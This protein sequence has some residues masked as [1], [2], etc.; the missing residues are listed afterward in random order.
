MTRVV[1]INRQSLVR[2]GYENLTDWLSDERHVYIG[3]AVRYVAGARQSKWAN[4]FSKKKYGRE[5]C[6]ALYEEYLLGN[7]QLLSQIDELEDKVLGCWCKPENCHGDVL[8][9]IL[10]SKKNN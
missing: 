10:N 4:P 8:V 9:R 6:I 2:K 3:R 1:N 5:K 7:E